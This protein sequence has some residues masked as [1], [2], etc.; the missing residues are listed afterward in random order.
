MSKFRAI[1][2]VLMSL[3][4]L[5]A[6]TS[7][8]NSA[9]AAGKAHVARPSLATDFDGFYY[10]AGN[11]TATGAPSGPVSVPW[12]SGGLPLVIVEG[13][14]PAIRGGTLHITGTANNATATVVAPQSSGLG[15]VTVAYKFHYAGKGP[16]KVV[17]T[18][19]GQGTDQSGNAVTYSGSF[20]GSKRA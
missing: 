16:A 1:Q 10:G 7:A 4:A 17:G 19:T 9:G 2:L 15:L 3:T 20:T 13:S 14:P 6:F 11:L 18:F 12:A 5:V 8:V